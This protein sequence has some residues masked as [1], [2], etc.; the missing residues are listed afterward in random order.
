M[1]E[2]FTRS[3]EAG[4]ID[5]ALDTRLRSAVGFRSIAVHDDEAIDWEIVRL[6][7]GAPLADFEAFARQIALGLI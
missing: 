4:L 3:G 6:L 7:A 1:G 5:T 2:T